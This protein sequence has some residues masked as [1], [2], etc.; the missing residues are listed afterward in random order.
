MI[1]NLF[2]FRYRFLLYNRK[3]VNVMSFGTT[4]IDVFSLRYE[5]IPRPIYPL[6]EID[7]W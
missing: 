3:T 1:K 6:D 2:P 4:D 7:T 5:T